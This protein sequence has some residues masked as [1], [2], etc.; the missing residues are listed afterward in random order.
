M[1][2]N[3]L[4]ALLYRGAAFF[5][6]LAAILLRIFPA[7]SPADYG[8]LLYLTLQTNVAMLLFTGYLVIKSAVDLTGNGVH[9]PVTYHPRLHGSIALLS[10]F[11][12]LIY[13]ALLARGKSNLFAFTNLTLHGIAPFL[14]IADYIVLCGRRFM[15]RTDPLLFAL[16]P[17]VY[18]AQASLVGLSGYIFEY[19]D[20]LPVHY[21]YFFMDYDRIGAL[22]AV[23]IG[24]IGAA[25]IGVGFLLYAFDQRP[26]K[27]PTT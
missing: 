21:P 17:T 11:V 1:I 16:L 23:F 27:P 9:G 3:R 2:Q 25:Y 12:V 8:A 13:W 7:A 10:F 4:F 14:F 6:S 15:K 20:A 18:I 19:K 22:A 26:E 5:I 24:G